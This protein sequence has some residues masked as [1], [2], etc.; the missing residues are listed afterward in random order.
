MSDSVPFYFVLCLVLLCFTPFIIARLFIRFFHWLHAH[1]LFSS[2]RPY[3]VLCLHLL[4]ILRL[5][6]FSVNTLSVAFHHC[7][8]LASIV[9]PLRRFVTFYLPPSSRRFVTLTFSR[10][11]TLTKQFLGKLAPKMRSCNVLDINQFASRS[12]ISDVYQLLFDFFYR[13]CIQL[14]SLFKC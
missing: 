11:T 2:I 6:V 10:L 7:P 13:I 9:A 3:F 1:F 4:F 5:W 12:L 8:S 14:S